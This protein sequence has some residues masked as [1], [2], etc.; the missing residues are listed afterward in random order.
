MREAN[1]LS[2]KIWHFYDTGGKDLSGIMVQSVYRV[3]EENPY[4]MADHVPGVGFKTAD[5]IASKVG[6][7]TDSDYRIRSGIFYTLI[8]SV[9]EGHVYLL[10]EVL[11]YRA[12]QLLDVEIQHIEKYV[13]DLAME[14]KVVLKES[15]EGFVFIPPIIIIWN[16]RL[17]R[18]CMI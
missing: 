3:I 9:S 18:C 16:S 10:Q 5:E 17:Q 6:I 14:K 7:H 13:M 1:D 15:D 12:S 11:L 4:Q 2:A 8:Q